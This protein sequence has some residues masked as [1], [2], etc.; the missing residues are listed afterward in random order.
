MES[1]LESNNMKNV[2]KA[3]AGACAIPIDEGPAADDGPRILDVRL[4]E[5]LG[6]PSPPDIR[7]LISKHEA[8]LTRLGDLIFQE[9]DGDGPALGA[10]L[11]TRQAAFIAT[12][13]DTPLAI[14]IT[15]NMV[16]SFVH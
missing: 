15:L 10:Y 4:A 9:L 7:R 8:S 11:N 1:H 3:G 2:D 16:R 14:D 6:F 5:L 13:A 12:K